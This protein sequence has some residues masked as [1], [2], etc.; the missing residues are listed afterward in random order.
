MPGVPVNA[1]FELLGVVTEPPAPVMMLQVPVPTVG[2][3]AANTTE[4]AHTVWSGPALAVVGAPFIVTCTS[5]KEAGQ[6]E[7]AISDLY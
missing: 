6:G 3:F 2:A 4:L 7:L 5:S 1:E